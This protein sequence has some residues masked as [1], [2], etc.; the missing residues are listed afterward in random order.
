M[1]NETEKA[2]IEFNLFNAKLQELEQ[3]L[4][5]IEKYINEL[6]ITGQG[7]EELKNMSNKE[8]LAPMGQGIFVKSKLQETKE[9]MV[10]IG[11]RVFAKKSIAEAQ[12]IINKKLIDFMALREDIGEQIDAILT[13]MQELD[14]KLK[15]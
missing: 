3:Q 15:K 2:I 1:E 4:Q 14:T 5:V 10:D 7:L 11:S 9:V 13:R 6:Q 12:G 8:M